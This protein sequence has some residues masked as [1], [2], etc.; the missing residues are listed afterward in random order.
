MAD[1]MGSAPAADIL[2]L[3]SKRMADAPLEEGG[4]FQQVLNDLPA[5]VYAT[6]AK[7]RI[8]YFNQAAA[9]LWGRSPELGKNEWCGSWKLY[10]PD[11]TPLAHGDCPMALA[12]KQKRANRGMEAIAERPDGTRIPFL[13]YPTPLFNPAG[14][15]VGAVN[16]LVDLTDRRQKED[17]TERLAAI[18][19]S[20]D[21]AI[22]SKNLDGVIT[23][24]NAGA[25]RLF[26]YT[27]G[28]AI[29]KPITLLIPEQ[30]QD[31]EPSILARIRRGERIEHYETVR[32]RKDGTLVDISLTVSPLKNRQGVVVGASK[33][34]R[35][36]TERRR[37]GE[38][39]QLLLREMN[40]RVKN[41]F[42]LVSG[43]VSLSARSA[44]TPQELASAV[45]ER[46]GA[47]ARAHALTL[48][49]VSDDFGESQ[50][51]PTLHAL[52]RTIVSPYDDPDREEER[53]VIIS[54]PDVPLS[55]S[56]ITSFA[57]LLHEFATNAAKYGALSV[58]AG[59]IRI[60][61]SEAGGM[62]DLCWTEQGGPRVE[63]T[64]DA[65]SDGEGF[66]S[67]LAR[68]TVQR[69]LAGEITRTWRPEGL[70]IRLSVTKDRLIG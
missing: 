60:D 9:E 64:V 36:V 8:T 55:A 58:P 66:G 6:D 29:G 11:G 32:Q 23:S 31:E 41:L 63:H 49:K 54:G 2:G 57:L 14:E 28:E 51:P 59:H 4:Y 5:A 16:M 50:P 33:I 3:S 24:W 43:V 19:A 18:V 27:P 39:Q 42:T 61:C 47:L 65:G 67:M 20:S 69:Q 40:H 53:R 34:A 12:I 46:L 7:G 30:L 17:L 13:P 70:V 22:I 48:P 62:F 10:W 26:G 1:D 21:D 68:S 44:K 45:R 52:I 35:D 15:L 37:S 56:C 38:L 25:E